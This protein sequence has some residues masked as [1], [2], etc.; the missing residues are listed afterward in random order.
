LVNP[1]NR[2]IDQV[3]QEE[4]QKLLSTFHNLIANNRGEVDCHTPIIIDRPSSA[5]P[6]PFEKLRPLKDSRV[7][8]F[9]HMYEPY[10][11][12]NHRLN[13]SLWS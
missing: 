4:V 6:N 11:D 1:E 12:T 8:Y 9:F 5:G 10:A 3:N 2:N 7:I 13:K